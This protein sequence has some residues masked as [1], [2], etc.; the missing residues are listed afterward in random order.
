MLK[1]L[2]LT[3]HASCAD[4]FRPFCSAQV[5]IRSIQS[6]MDVVLFRARLDNYFVEP[7]YLH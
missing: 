4:R 3:S 7:I 1:T 6:A 2:P 5:H